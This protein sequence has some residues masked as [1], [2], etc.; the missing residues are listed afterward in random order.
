MNAMCVCS[1]HGEEQ[2]WL[3]VEGQEETEV[4]VGQR[5]P[6]LLICRE[7]SSTHR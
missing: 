7:I 3:V 4:L 2:F 5:G 1:S 6:T